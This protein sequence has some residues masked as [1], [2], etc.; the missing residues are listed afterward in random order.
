[1]LPLP[2]TTTIDGG[3]GNG[4]N[5]GYD[6][7]FA[8]GSLQLP[9]LGGAV[10]RNV[11]LTVVNGGIV[12]LSVGSLV[13]GLLVGGAVRCDVGLMVV[14]D[15][16]VRLGIGSLIG[17][18]LDVGEFFFNKC[19][20]LMFSIIL[21]TSSR[22]HLHRHL[23]LARAT[24]LPSGAANAHHCHR[25]HRRRQQRR[26]QSVFCP[27]PPLPCSRPPLHQFPHGVVQCN[28]SVDASSLLRCYPCGTGHASIPVVL[29]L[30]CH[31][32]WHQQ[33]KSGCVAVELP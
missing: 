21:P 4:N 10:G 5:D 28:S 30:C 31:C 29:P 23:P 15:S 20:R 6:Q 3:G 14:G 11:C 18:S 24:V 26:Q 27:L 32:W 8:Q 7:P 9:P 25:P 13:L 33:R 2:S 12:G 1:L 17:G 22:S 19:C 16:V